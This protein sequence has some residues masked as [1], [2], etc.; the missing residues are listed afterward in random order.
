M[1]IVAFLLFF[2]TACFMAAKAGV[3]SGGFHECNPAI[4][5]A[6]CTGIYFIVV[7][8]L[9]SSANSAVFLAVDKGVKL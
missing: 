9:A 8:I 5:G 2:C 3:C 6:I 4:G 1:A 7:W